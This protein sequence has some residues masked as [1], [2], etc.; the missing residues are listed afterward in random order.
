M[1]AAGDMLSAAL[2]E[3]CP[4]PEVFVKRLNGLGLAGVRFEMEKRVKCGIT[5]TGMRVFVDGHEEACGDVHEIN[6]NTDNH[7]SDNHSQCNHNI[8]NHND[9]HNQNHNHDNNHN[10]SHL[11]THYSLKDIDDI[12]RGA[13]IDNKVKDD[14]MAV[15]RLIAEAESR[16]HQRKVEELHFHEVGAMDAIADVT[17]V[18]MLIRE[19]SP[20]RIVVSPINVGSGQVRCAHGIL[21]VPAPATAVLLNGVPTY[22]TGINGELCTPTG[23]ALLKYFADEFGSQ[24]LM[25]VQSIGYGFGKKDFEQANC[26]RAMLGESC[27]V[28]EQIYELCCNID[29]MTAED[30][31]FAAEELMKGGALDVYTLYAGMKKGRQGIVLNCICAPDKREHLARLIFK[32]TTTLGIRERVCGRY[33]ME[34]SVEKT[35]TE[36][37]TV[38]IKTA[39]GWGAERSKPEFDDIAAI[40]R[41]RGMSL[42]ELR[43]RLIK[44]L[45]GKNY[46]TI[47]PET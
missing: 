29:D 27:G 28:R 7:N 23:A 43:E 19:L 35:A 21:P 36:Y 46:F 34:R 45:S 12:V 2:L 41:E 15:Y 13:D 39:S 38:R 10:H 31:A 17:A 25:S 16:V 37:G 8:D 9:D 30:I 20:D 11:H 33:T 22:S 4:E 5:G 44:E 6:N 47:K 3:L 1:G 26:V 42:A 40:A 24:P 14:V 32:H 18:C